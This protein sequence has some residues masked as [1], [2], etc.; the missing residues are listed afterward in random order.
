MSSLLLN[1]GIGAC[2]P[3]LVSSSACVCKL[4]R[5]RRWVREQVGEE[6]SF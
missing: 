4:Q 3:G 2:S 1:S 6:S 5:G